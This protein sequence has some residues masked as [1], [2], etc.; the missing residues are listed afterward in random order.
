MHFSA[1]HIKKIHTDRPCTQ[2][3]TFPHQR[4]QLQHCEDPEGGGLTPFISLQYPCWKKPKVHDFGRLFVVWGAVY[5]LEMT[6]CWVHQRPRKSKALNISARRNKE[7]QITESCRHIKNIRS[8][9]DECRDAS[10]LQTDKSVFQSHN[11]VCAQCKFNALGYIS[12]PQRD[13]NPVTRFSTKCCH[14][15]KS[16][17][18]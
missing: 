11:V 18:F 16:V 2:A 1:D 8:H 12:L 6:A 4:E 13:S 10:L 5:I 7:H 17:K 9:H 3:L 15:P 14:L